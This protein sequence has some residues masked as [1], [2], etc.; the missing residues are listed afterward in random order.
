MG[1]FPRGRCGGCEWSG[2]IGWI[3]S[4]RCSSAPMGR[5]SSPRRVFSPVR[6]IAALST[7]CHSPSRSSRRSRGSR[8]AS[9]A[10][11]PDVLPA[12]DSCD[13]RASPRRGRHLPGTTNAATLGH[14]TGARNPLSGQTEN[15]TARQHAR[16]VERG[17]RRR[18]GCGPHEPH[19]ASD[20][21][22]DPAQSPPSR[23]A[24]SNLLPT[25]RQRSVG[26]FTGCASTNPPIL[27]SAKWWIA[28][29]VSNVVR[30][31][32]HPRRWR[33][34]RGGAPLLER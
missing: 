8:T 30:P 2:S 24:R 5:R 1:A 27:V 21:R 14:T 25:T 18:C 3:Q 26:P 34:R 6:G 20:T 9:V 19:N 15:L 33:S 4:S 32:K 13:R 16:R 17:C 23:R 7:V 29:S 28:R 10:D 22:P 31:C 12:E 11:L